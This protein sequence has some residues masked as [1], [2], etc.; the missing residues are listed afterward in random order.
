MQQFI[1]L[2]HESILK[3]LHRCEPNRLYNLIEFMINDKDGGG[4]HSQMLL[5]S[6]RLF[7]FQAPSMKTK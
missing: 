3:T 1:F 6:W 7:S 4:E 5:V 2:F